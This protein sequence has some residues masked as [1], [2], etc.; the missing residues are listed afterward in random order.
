MAVILVH[1]CVYI[2]IHYN[3]AQAEA[4]TILTANAIYNSVCGNVIVI[5]FIGF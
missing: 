2:Q 4:M 5:V 1:F 3:I